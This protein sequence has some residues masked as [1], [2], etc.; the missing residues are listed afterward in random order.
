MDKASSRSPRETFLIGVLVILVLAFVAEH[1][2]LL[3]YN[4]M[5]PAFTLP[6]CEAPKR[7]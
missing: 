7:P 3:S 6:P 4:V 2:W 1:I 5:R